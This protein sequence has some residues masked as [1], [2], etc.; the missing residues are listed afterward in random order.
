MSPIVGSGECMSKR[1]CR[2]IYI[3]IYIYIDMNIYMCICIYS[4][5]G[6]FIV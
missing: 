2:A 1:T 6:C 4:K 5:R 3:Y